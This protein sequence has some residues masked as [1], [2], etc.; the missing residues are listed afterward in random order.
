MSKADQFRQYADEAMGWAFQSKTKNEKEILVE[1]A[2]LL[3]RQ[4]TNRACSSIEGKFAASAEF[5][6]PTA[7][8][9][10]RVSPHKKP[11]RVGSS[12]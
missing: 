8:T 1:R 11:R 6:R 7:S 10:E 9:G 3:V 2:G 12:T 5:L 4:C